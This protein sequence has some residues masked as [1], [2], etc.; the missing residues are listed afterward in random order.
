MGNGRHRAFLQLGRVNGDS[1]LRKRA[2]ALL[3]VF[4]LALHPLVAYANPQGGTVSGGSATIN[5]SGN[6]VTINQTSNKSIIDWNSFNIG[7]GETTVFNQPGSS[8][9]ALNRVHDANPSQILGQL[10]ANGHIILVNPNGVFFGKGS[11]IDVSGLIATTANISNA[12][13]MNGSMNFNQP[14]NPNASIINQGTI[15]AGNAGLV[16]FIAPQVQNDGVITAKLGKVALASGD[17]FTLDM[18]GDNLISVAVSDAVNKELAANSGTI[19]A[20]GGTVTMTAAAARSV[21]DSLVSNSGVVQAD[22]IQNVNGRIV[23]AAGSNGGASQVVNSGTISASGKASGQNGGDITVTGDNVDLT[24]TSVIDASGDAGGGSVKVGGGFHGQG[25]TQTAQNT[26]VEAGSTIDASAITSGNGGNVAVWSNNNTIFAGQINANGGATSGNGGFVE[27]SGHNLIATG[28][29]NAGATNGNSGTWLLDPNNID[30]EQASC[31]GTGCASANTIGTS[32]SGGTNVTVTTTDG[33]IT[34]GGTATA[35][36]TDSGRANT[37][38]DFEAAADIVMSH[39]SAI[40]NSG[41]GKLNVTFDADTA[42]G[43]G[44]ISIGSG[45][46]ITTGGGNIIMGGQASPATLAAVGDATYVTG[47]TIAGATLNAGGGNITITGKGTTGGNAISINGGSI[48]TTSGGGIISVA[49]TGGMANDNL[50]IYISDSNTVISAGNGAIIISA[51]GSPFDNTGTLSAADGSIAITANNISQQGTITATGGSI[52]ENYTGAYADNVSAVTQAEGGDITITGGNGSSFFSS[53]TYDVSNAA[54]TGGTIS[55]TASHMSLYAATLNAS[56]SAGGGTIDVGG[57]L[58]GGGTL[59]HAQDVTLNPYTTLNADATGRGEGGTIAV[60][61]DTKTV[62]GAWASAKGGPQGGNGGTIE[63]SSGGQDY[64]GG[65][66]DASAPHGASGTMLIDP[67]DIIISNTSGSGG[68][69]EYFQLVNP[70]ASGSSTGFGTDVT[71]LSNGN[72]VVTNPSDNLNASNAGAV[73][74]FNGATG[75][76]ITRIARQ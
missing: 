2:A 9:I 22:S 27:T 28:S 29:V 64:V 44:A 73:F 62:Y 53:G 35:T 36:I 37:T 52:S 17:T 33:S 54:S 30:I 65:S 63:V 38:L 7:S 23:L 58:H 69:L 57:A 40:T 15:T 75:A 59:A 76:L 72:V 39:S 6:T 41:S 51:E 18:A 13:F 1:Y 12:D 24:P 4:Y 10:T 60:W 5:Q 43:G 25:T 16:G 48:V 45:S 55:L 34:L 71:V 67:H 56:G 42:L 32:L 21:V 61:S 20:D 68:G 50:G 26:T 3:A 70:D 66:T 11:Q 47:I 31:T 74:L 46:S 14:G 8:S 19:A 49:N